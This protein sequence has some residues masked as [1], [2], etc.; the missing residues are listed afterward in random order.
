MEERN[1]WISLIKELRAEYQIEILEAERMALS[2]L[3]WRRWVAHQIRN[4]R[5]C[6]RMAAFHVR[7][8]GDAA[9]LEL[10]DGHYVV[11]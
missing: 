8:N 11:K 2:R 7:Q 3:E 10:R 6:R 9:L 4:D 1:R 5:K